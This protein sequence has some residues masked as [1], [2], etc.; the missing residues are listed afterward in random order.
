MCNKYTGVQKIPYLLIFETEFKLSHATILQDG[1]KFILGHEQWFKWGRLLFFIILL[2]AAE[3]R[4]FFSP[5]HC[6]HNDVFIDPGTL[7]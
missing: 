7:R 4:L 6:V 5:P 1:M 3:E 2:K